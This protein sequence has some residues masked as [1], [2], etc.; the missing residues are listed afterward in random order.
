MHKCCYRSSPLLRRGFGAE[1]PSLLAPVVHC[2]VPAAGSRG[3]SHAAATSSWQ[4]SSWQPCLRAQQSSDRTARTR[5]APLPA[6]GPLGQQRGQRKHRDLNQVLP[7]PVPPLVPPLLSAGA[8]TSGVRRDRSCSTVHT[9]THPGRAFLGN[10]SI[11]STIPVNPL[12]FLALQYYPGPSE[13]I[14]LSSETGDR[15]ALP[16]RHCLESCKPAGGTLCF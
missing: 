4:T 7:S 8:Q 2:S 5:S 11:S 13:R 9:S 14:P 1:G 6:P 15:A 16:S 10:R 12:W 3:M